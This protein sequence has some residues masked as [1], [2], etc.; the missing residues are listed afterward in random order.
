MRK[1]R[2]VVVV[3]VALTFA[4][5]LLFL[6]RMDAHGRRGFL[7]DYGRTLRRMVAGEWD[8]DEL[9]EQDR[10]GRGRRRG[11]SGSWNVAEVFE[12]LDVNDDGLLGDGELGNRM[13]TELAAMGMAGR[14]VTPEVLWNAIYSQPILSPVGTSGTATQTTAADV[15]PIR[16]TADRLF[17]RGHVVRVDVQ[18]DP[19]DWTSLCN[20]SRNHRDA[21]RNP[22]AKPYTNFRA[23]VTV[24][25]Y[26]I[27]D[28]AIRK[29]GFIGSQ[30]TERPSLKIAFDEY[31]DQDPIVGLDRLTLNNNKQDDSLLS[32]TMTYNLFRQVGVHAPRCGFA[33]VTVN[34]RYL[35]VYSHVE[36]VRKPFLQ[37]AFGD[38]SGMLYEGTLTDLHPDAIHWFEAK[39]KKKGDRARLQELSQ[40]LAD[41][42]STIE[43]VER[44]VDV[45]EFLR[46]WVI[47][48]L[49]NFWDGY[50]QNQNNF[51]MYWN[52]RDSR[53]HFM[54]WGAD[55][56]FG[57]RYGRNRSNAATVAA[58]SILANRLYHM[59][60]V[61]DRY[62][63]TLQSIMRDQWNEA[64]LLR[65]VDELQ[66][67]VMQHIG[68]PQVRSLTSMDAM[69]AFIRDRR[70][71]VD[72]ELED[73]PRWV[74]DGPDLPRYDVVVGRAKGSFSVGVGDS[75]F[76]ARGTVD[77]EMSIGDSTGSLV[78]VRAVRTGN[79]A[80][81]VTFATVIGENPQCFDL[82]FGKSDLELNRAL[83]ANGQ[84]GLSLTGMLLPDPGYNSLRG[85]ATLT[86]FSALVDGTIAGEFDIQLL[87]AR[88]GFTLRRGW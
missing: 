84:H 9:F 52:P 25:G 88:G 64:H 72:A 56:C 14:P 79:D 65:E 12:K 28:V 47:E 58:K 27:K 81:V 18:I 36:S 16:L 85:T 68:F 82:R 38:D 33:A 60:G 73:W 31:V 46:Y 49:I 77:G 34:G 80:V 40:V 7:A 45:D 78:E 63:K 62:L 10:R 74:Q 2:K 24:D 44:L 87:E 39:T 37:R 69:R 53:F 75:E 23:D 59:S 11:R 67:I 3:I 21:V 55:S 48:S 29:K 35:G 22:I 61:P 26:L 6:L 32:Q 66:D 51:F 42:S 70:A 4:V 50:T 83:P 76:P 43:D 17:A 57:A 54:P 19:A 8:P 1:L 5:V 71:L 13:R 15:Q 86:E 20:Q 30:D 41:T